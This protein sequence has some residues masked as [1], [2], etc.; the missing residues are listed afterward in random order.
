MFSFQFRSSLPGLLFVILAAVVTVFAACGGGGGGNQADNSADDSYQPLTVDGN[1]LKFVNEPSNPLVFHGTDSNG[2]SYWFYAE[3]D[4]DGIP[5]YIRE[6]KLT[7]VDQDGQPAEEATMYL[8]SRQR[9]VRVVL[10][11]LQGE[12]TLNYVSDA[13]VEVTVHAPDGSTDTFLLDNPYNQAPQAGLTPPR[14]VHEACDSYAGFPS[15]Q[16]QGWAGEIIACKN[17]PKPIVYIEKEILGSGGM[18]ERHFPDLVK[19]D[20]D[21]STITWSYVYSVAAADF[22]QW[23]AYCKCMYWSSWALVAGKLAGAAYSKT[24]SIFLSAGGW[25]NSILKDLTK[26][27][28]NNTATQHVSNIVNKK[29]GTGAFTFIQHLRQAIKEGIPPCSDAAYNKYS[30]NAYAP[31]KIVCEYNKIRQVSNFTPPMSNADKDMPKFD[32]SSHCCGQV[33]QAGGDTPETHTHELG[34]TKGTVTFDY[35]T[36]YIKDQIIVYY[37]G[38]V[39]FDS[40]C[41]GEK[42]SVDLHFEGS[43]HTLTVKVNPNC[44]GSSGTAW[45]YTLHCPTSAD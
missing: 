1:P 28:Y 43:S 33:T 16:T 25:V 23:E 39:L 38:T 34:M 40:G 15:H 35:N 14:G 32:F 18:V 29:L 27:T 20:E 4:Q 5:L 10:P 21:T 7:S 8:D 11:D 36:Y 42:K 31:I 41:V 19:L 9:P 44:S 12:I 45:R 6:M 22:D 17:G 26:S 13:Q 37:D 2:V 24:V 3:K 30:Q